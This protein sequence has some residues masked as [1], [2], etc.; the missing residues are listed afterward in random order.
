MEMKI[1]GVDART[2]GI[3]MG[4]GFLNAIVAP[5]PMKEFIENNSRLEHG[6]QMIYANPRLADREVTLSFIVSG[7]DEHEFQ[8]NLRAFET[9]LYAGLVELYVQPTGC[10]YRL[11]YQRSQSY[12]QNLGRTSCNVSVK[13]NEPNPANRAS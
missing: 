8:A 3:R 13:F 5:A 1:N 6:K 4:E 7:T 11:T 12:A 10:T 2:L 9:I